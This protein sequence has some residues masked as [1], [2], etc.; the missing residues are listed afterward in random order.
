[1]TRGAVAS[2]DPYSARAGAWVLESGGNA[3]DAAVAMGIMSGFT[4]PTMAGLGG[5]G[6][7]TYRVGDLVEVCDGFATVPGLGRPA[8]RA[9]DPVSVEVDFEGVNV[10][11]RIGPST[12]AV[13]GSA[14]S[15]WEVHRRH[16]RMPMAEVALP[17][18]TA[19]RDGVP[20]SRAVDT[21]LNLLRDILRFTPGAWDIVKREDADDTLR[22]GDI[23]RNEPMAQTLEQLVEEGPAL[24]YEGDVA[25]AIVDASGG[26]VTLED[27][28]TYRPVFREPLTGRY[29]RWT[30]MT[31][32]IPSLSG[33]M[34]LAALRHLES[35]GPLPRKLD[36]E[37]WARLIAG[38]RAGEAVR[39][40]DYEHRLFED[41]YL[42]EVL[43][44]RPWGS[45]MQCSAVDVWGNVAS[46]TTTAGESCGVVA[47]GTGILLNNFL[48][49]DD[50]EPAGGH[51]EPGSRML[52]SIC[53]TLLTDGARNWMALG[54]A[55]SSRIRSAIVQA[56]VH[57]VDGGAHPHEAL[58]R[59]RVHWEADTLYIEGFGRTKREVDELCTLVDRA[60]VTRTSG[61]FFGGVQ[62]VLM[63]GDDFHAGADQERRGGAAMVV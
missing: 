11:F 4:L 7:L 39:T 60:E 10:R 2:G 44:S 1:M 16:G 33:C 50:I 9:A 43:H 41:G 27:L 14:A 38:L 47:A 26:G 53:P 61:F 54:A 20:V 37:G 45:T 24:F 8:M 28:G 55:G 17:T 5:A 57:T 12:I 31:P 40:H 21:A 22:A 6:I 48:G 18:I 19:A 62:A 56:I 63:N 46:Y 30:V 52:T 29:R 25:R 15:L 49:E 32:G 13:P 51:R 23:M 59:P 36:K 42:E 58:Q 3:I 35:E 34:V